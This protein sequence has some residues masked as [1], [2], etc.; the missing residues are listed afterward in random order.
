M[1][2]PSS[3][4]GLGLVHDA[5]GFPDMDAAVHVH[6]WE[7]SKENFQPAKAGRKAASLALLA[8]RDEDKSA[9]SEANSALVRERDAYLK[10][11]A[12]D[13]SDD[14]LATWLKFVK[15][16][17]ENFATTQKAE[18]LPILEKCTRELLTFSKRNYRDD[19][20]F[21][22]VW[23]LYAECVE[24]ARDIF[25]FCEVNN[26]GQTHALYYEAAA[27]FYEFKKDYKR[28]DELYRRG[29]E[30]GAKPAERL[31]SKYDAFQGR[32]ARRIQKQVASGEQPQRT[33][34]EEDP[35][36]NDRRFGQGVFGTSSAPLN[37][38]HGARQQ[39]QQQ[40]HEAARA[41]QDGSLAVYSDADEGNPGS[42]PAQTWANLPSR[43][44]MRKE[45]DG[46]R[47]GT[48]RG[49]NS[50][51]GA[52]TFMPASST[53]PSSSSIDLYVDDEFQR[54]EDAFADN[55]SAH[56]A[57]RALTLRERLDGKVER[58]VEDIQANPLRNHLSAPKAGS[59]KNVAP[60]APAPAQEKLGYDPNLLQGEDGEE[61]CF[62]ENRAALWLAN[63]GAAS[64]PAQ[65][66]G[67][68]GD[69]VLEVYDDSIAGADDMN[70]SPAAPDKID[71]D[72]GD[73]AHLQSQGQQ[74]ELDLDAAPAAADM[75]DNTT[76]LPPRALFQ[77]CDD[78]VSL[79]RRNPRAVAEEDATLCTREAFAN[80]LSVFSEELPS[81]LKAERGAGAAISGSASR[82]AGGM[83]SIAQP[84]SLAVFADDDFVVADGS[85]S[86]T[87]AMALSFGV[88]DENADKD[89]VAADPPPRAAR[90]PLSVVR[91]ERLDT[92]SMDVDASQP[93]E[94][95]DNCENAAPSD[96]APRALSPR[97][98]D[99]PGVEG[100]VLQPLS[101]SRR[102]VLNA[103]EEPAP[104][105]DSLPGDE[106]VEM[107]SAEVLMADAAAAGAAA[108][109][110]SFEV[111]DDGTGDADVDVGLVG[112][113]G[114]STAVAVGSFVQANLA[115]DST[116][117]LAEPSLAAPAVLASMCPSMT[118][119]SARAR[120]RSSIGGGGGGGGAAAMAAAVAAT[121][122]VGAVEC[123][124]DAGADDELANA[125]DHCDPSFREGLLRELDPPLAQRGDVFVHVK[126]SDGTGG[127]PQGLSA[128]LR[129]ARQAPGTSAP[130]SV[131]P[132]G[133]TVGGGV[134][135]FEG[136]PWLVGGMLGTGSYAS[137]YSARLLTAEE[138][139]LSPTQ[140]MAF[141][142][143]SDETMEGSQDSG[144][145]DDVRRA[146]KVQHGTDA[147][148]GAWEFY[149]LREIQ[150]RLRMERDNIAVKGCAMHL[151]G[152]FPRARA[153][154]VSD[155]GLLSV[156]CLS[157]HTGGTVQDLV[158]VHL[159]SGRR[160]DESLA[161]FYAIELLSS[162]AA[163]HSQGIAHGDVKP[164]N[165]LLRGGGSR[166]GQPDGEWEDWD[167]STRQGAWMGTGIVLCDYG[168]S[169]DL[170]SVPMDVAGAL[171]ADD[172]LGIADVIHVLLHGTYLEPEQDTERGVWRPKQACRRYQKGWLWDSVFE[173]LLN[174][175]ED[176]PNLDQIKTQL[177]EAL[178]NEVGA[179]KKVRLSL[180]KASI[181]LQQG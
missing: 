171:M 167:A 69:G 36:L 5:S 126:E 162:V 77:D 180:M 105:A 147:A 65:N 7:D 81:E 161:C 86:A 96:V 98:L 104:A 178:T 160:L 142:V 114:P 144:M 169:A 149:T 10:S 113:V 102:G 94:Y 88:F 64:V 58:S 59:S 123:T 74:E 23:V 92:S 150:S 90:A 117:E 137:V 110:D 76:V 120:R 127:E 176:G 99:D 79:P 175:P 47:V 135:E 39:Q 118:P 19:V 63:N 158:N 35:D 20:R 89:E 121:T 129:R 174:P 130:G 15:W 155:D 48:L 17:Q 78:T 133:G 70:V 8:A 173:Q 143:D 141:E 107:P 85:A 29:I 151:Q 11:L 53:A 73:A 2:P 115:G 13:T 1:A 145:D 164:D 57:G 14:P 100:H 108:L 166:D 152:A 87:P 44:D 41:D 159:A 157:R 50:R 75:E 72:G 103:V 54:A 131:P 95:D 32:M 156:L 163:L 18:L 112:S 124:P 12:E 181:A 34:E 24:D 55:A 60:S 119:P 80:V 46:T 153:L 138:G 109:D 132:R 21:L 146:I 136:Q 51:A 42:M 168:R 31:Q 154:H 45:N 91:E 125:F 83:P 67:D 111:F 122:P 61:A 165:I 26:I 128:A 9:S 93:A 33:T 101:P 179:P 148:L 170:L 84:T 66:S 56:P 4:D 82:G 140:L 106:N 43:K 177:E 52:G 134:V 22:R 40:Q 3:S 37:N 28:V 27:V 71:D 62:E 6:A 38:A 30:A 172:A 25:K 116:V 16:T 97:C 139:V 68:S 49:G